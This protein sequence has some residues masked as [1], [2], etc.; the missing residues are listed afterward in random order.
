[1]RSSASDADAIAALELEPERADELVPL[2]P[3][4]PDERVRLQHLP[5][6][7]FT[8]VGETDAT[9]AP[10][11][12]STA[13]SSSALL[14]VL[15]ELRLEHREQLRPGLDEDH[16]RLLLRDVRVVLGE[17]PRYSSAIAPAVSTPVGPAA[18]DD[19]VQRAVLDRPGRGRRPPMLEHVIL[20][21]DGVGQRVHRKRVL[22]RA[23]DPKKLTSAPS[24]STR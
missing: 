6:L 19:D 17:V 16:A 22:G 7:S 1:M 10:V 23:F 8:R 18:D 5:D 21:P 14:R 20:E 4:A 3:G 9:S 2:E 13:A 15:A 24:P 12:T 11:I